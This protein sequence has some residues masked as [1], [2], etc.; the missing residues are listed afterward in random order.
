MDLINRAFFEKAQRGGEGI[1]IGSTPQLTHKHKVAAKRLPV[2]LPSR[3]HMSSCKV[4]LLLNAYF[5]YFQH[6]C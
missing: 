4:S 6:A 2:T 3:T 5:Q 1:R